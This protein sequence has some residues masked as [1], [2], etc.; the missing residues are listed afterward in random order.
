M[1]TLDPK[2]ES[3]VGDEEANLLRSRKEYRSP[4]MLPEV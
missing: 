2:T 3:F 1:L 4:W